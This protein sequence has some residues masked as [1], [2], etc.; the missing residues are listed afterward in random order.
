MN[1]GKS[2][3]F[4]RLISSNKSLAFDY[5]GVTRDFIS[6]VTSWQGTDFELV[7]SGG[8]TSLKALDKITKEIQESVYKLLETADLVIFT[9]D[10][11][12][13]VT[14]EDRKILSK[15]RK[16]NK[17]IILVINKSDTKAA[18]ENQYEFSGLGFEN[19][20]FVSAL[21]SRGIGDLLD[22][23]VSNLSSFNLNKAKSIEPSFRIT[24]LGKPNVGK[25]SLINL[26][27]KEYRS[28]VTDEAGTTREAVD[29]KINFHKES[30]KITDTAGIRR[31]KS[32]AGNNLEEL[33]V[34][35]SFRAVKHSDI[36][37]LLI[38]SFKDTLSD[39]ELKLA[40][41]IFNLNKALIVLF[42]KKDLETDHSQF[43]LN[44][45]V[46]KYGHFF[47]KIE[48][49]NISCKTNKNI[50]KILPLAKTVWDRSNQTFDN[51]ELNEILQK[52]L[53]DKP[54]HHKTNLL[55]LRK[56]KQIR[57]NPIT[58]ILFVNQKVWFGDS[59]V[60]YLENILRKHYQLKSVPVKFI[61]R[62]T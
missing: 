41:Y 17:K 44:D 40:F 16:L 1:V 26:L 57:S 55:I 4:N 5:A 56:A 47:R 62:Q 50:S 30:I 48:T 43:N 18:E 31:Q 54:L 45:R 3:I 29:T 59:Q 49:L 7:D 34:K 13:G 15:L 2:S 20:L 19:P 61:V 60:A 11:T 36:V 33:M 8:I 37:L 24:L 32:V 27:T 6:D 14:S 52:A 51:L 10:G 22:E 23:I 42:N 53:R 35:S 21:H 12:T 28:I 25:S 39:Q 38:D 9:C 58:I 46:E